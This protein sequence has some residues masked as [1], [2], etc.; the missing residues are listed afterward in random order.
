MCVPIRSAAER[1]FPQ[2]SETPVEDRA[3]CLERIADAVEARLDDF[4]ELES[5]D[6]GKPV[7]LARTV[8]IP[9][10]VANLRFF[11]QAVRQQEAPSTEMT[12][13]INYTQRMPVGVAAL[14]TPWNLSVRA[15]SHI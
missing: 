12:G 11:A 5:M 7:Q 8:D 1:A 4:A 15:P 14:I 6:T 2:W 10:A 13:A 9:R 3:R